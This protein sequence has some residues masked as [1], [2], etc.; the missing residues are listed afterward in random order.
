MNN[1]N[2]YTQ[3]QRTYSAATPH[4][5]ALKNG[6]KPC[7][8]ETNKFYCISC[9]NASDPQHMII[10]TELHHQNDGSVRNEI[11]KFEK[12]LKPQN[13]VILDDFEEEEKM[14][15][16]KH[17]GQAFHIYCVT[18]P[19]QIW[20][21]WCDFMRYLHKVLPI[22][23]FT[24]SLFLFLCLIYESIHDHNIKI[25]TIRSIQSTI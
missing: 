7:D 16:V 21:R 4:E 23:T 12:A 13:F 18:F 24:D 8:K 20:R 19:D 15:R 1:K 9:L 6:I 10:C 5:L 22:N 3:N 17:Y 11:A 14:C 2:I 25:T